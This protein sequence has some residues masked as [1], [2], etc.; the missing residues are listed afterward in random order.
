MA[1]LPCRSTAIPLPWSATERGLVGAA[2][3][4]EG[5]AA[6]AAGLAGDV[7]VAAAIHGDAVALVAAGAPQQC[8]V[9]QAGR[10]AGV[11]VELGDEDV[12]G[13]AA[14]GSLIGATG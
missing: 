14:E 1:A 5:G 10:A 7:G 2:R 9:D 11:G 12:I 3:G 13:A 8:T 6:G 4:R